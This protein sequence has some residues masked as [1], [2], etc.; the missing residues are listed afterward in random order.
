MKKNLLLLLVVFLPWIAPAQVSTPVQRSDVIEKIGDNKYYIHYVQQGQTLQTISEAY[1]IT[2]EKILRENAELKR[3]I[4]PG[5]VIRIPF[6]SQAAIKVNQPKS[7]SFGTP[8]P[9]VSHT[10]LKGETL[11]GIARL[12]NISVGDLIKANQDIETVKVGQVLVIPLTETSASV[13]E[14]SAKTTAV[15]NETTG[16][17][18]ISRVNE[19]GAEKSYSDDNPEYY[20]VKQGETLYS[21]SQRFGI[22]IAE[23]E[24]LNPEL[25]NGL[26]AGQTL[27][28]KHQEPKA[29][30]QYSEVQDTT[31]TYIYHRVHRRET[32]Y[33]LSKKYNVPGDHILKYNPQAAG[34]IKA[35]QVLQIPVYTITT[36]RVMKEE[37][38]TAPVKSEIEVLERSKLMDCNSLHPDEKVY[39]IALMIPF[40]LDSYDDD[41][42][43]DSE[44]ESYA[45][46]SESKKS[47]EFMQFY[48]GSLLAIDSLSKLGFRSE[49]YVY[50]VNNTPKSLDDVMRKPEL[51]KMDLIIGPLYSGSFERVA[52]F[53]REHKISIVNPLSL[54]S[55][56]LKNNPYAIKAQPSKDA[57]AM[58]VASYINE[59]LPEHNVIIVRQFT[60]SNSEFASVLKQELKNKSVQEVIYLRDS[61][62]GITRK[63]D[64]NKGNLVIGLS[65]DKV[66]VI[67]LVRKLNDIR[68]DYNITCFGLE[69]W[70]EFSLES[71]HMVNL[72]LH[73]ISDNFTDFD[74]EQV[75]KFILSFRNK[76]NA[77]P[78][79][80]RFA[81][82][83][84]D[85]SWYFL[86]ALYKFGNNFMDCLP[87]YKYRGLQLMFDFEPTAV[88]G[89]ENKGLTI[90][91]LD[92]YK[93]VEVYP[94][95]QQ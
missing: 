87:S 95:N 7:E 64:K 76:F 35:N 52:S 84:F 11:Y 68:A 41:Y 59:S 66:F 74:S 14:T 50:D 88:N 46:S 34:G 21:I 13:T 6:S 32:L 26:K 4:K 49:I 43:Y 17:I 53:A 9:G 39:N 92:N 30:I 15:S 60:Y 37:P 47:F 82:A 5:D 94:A 58:L 12:Y 36:R 3:D 45:Q 27:K 81:F 80:E 29:K 65:N 24:T 38:V 54:R 25:V 77:E 51:K 1:N 10:V 62:A 86:S 16:N 42:F 56:F 79:P 91:K 61:I 48:F 33:S 18:T 22:S 67:D 75:K 55:D 72:N 78:I 90:C 70:K 63:L 89:M 20:T 31:V 57:Q 2:T 83:A 23:L 85:I 44:S 71:E 19:Q 93:R 73:L 8:S 28:I 40:F 69:E